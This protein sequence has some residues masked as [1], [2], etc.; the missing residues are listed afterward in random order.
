MADNR[1]P[2]TFDSRSCR[3]YPSDLFQ[4]PRWILHPP[5]PNHICPNTPKGF[6]NRKFGN[7]KRLCLLNGSSHK[8]VDYSIKLDD[9]APSLWS[10]YGPSS[11]LLATPPLCPASVL[12]FSW[13]HHLNFSLH[14]G[15]TVSHVPHKKPGSDSCRFYA[16]RRSGSKQV[17]PELI[18]MFSKPPV[19]TSS[20]TFRHLISGSLL[21]ISLILT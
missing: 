4:T 21:L 12:S 15:A 19:L 14:I 7:T 11:L 18:L 20:F 16:G 2:T 17:S 1:S 9:V 13:G 6:H 3:D 5:L 10:H 8:M